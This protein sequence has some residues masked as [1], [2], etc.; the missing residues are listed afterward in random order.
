MNILHVYKTYLPEDFTGIPR[1]IHALAEG[2]A[3]HG[4]DTQVLALAQNPA[5][6]RVT[7]GRHQVHLARR[8]VNISSAGFSLSA[9]GLFA[10]LARKADVVNYHF[11]WPMADIMH[12]VRPHGR[13]SV[14]TYHSD[15]IKQKR[16]LPFYAPVRDRF[17]EQADAIIATSPS[18]VQSS[19]VLQRFAGK[20]S[21]AAIGMPERAL[22]DPDLIAR[23]RHRLG[24]RFFLFVGTLRYYKGMQYLLDAARISGL[25]V[26]IAGAD[27]ANTWQE[28]ASPNVQFLGEVTEA[29]KEALLSLCAGFVL[30]SHLRSEAFGIALLEAA[31]AGRPMVSCEIGTGTSYINIDG[32]TGFVVPPEN[33]QALAEAMLQ[34]SRDREGA[35]AMGQRARRRYE[36][37]FCAPRMVENYLEIYQRVIA[38]R[39]ANNPEQGL[40]LNA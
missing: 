16:L 36:Q 5:E 6:K 17:L 14:V 12:L 20:T 22:P 29:D 34:L 1:V 4:M 15:V 19:P 35:E 31:R 10:R 26:V 40:L 23:W 39:K 7:I 9:F 21:V 27:G 13:P 25:P 30:A 11:P 37:E 3:G 2:M 18:Y 24:E 33:G 32:E 28:G 8:D 38:A